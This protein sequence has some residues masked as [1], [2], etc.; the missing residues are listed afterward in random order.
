MRGSATS[1]GR[2]GLLRPL[3]PFCP[4]PAFGYQSSQP[5][6]TEPAPITLAQVVPR[7][8]EAYEDPDGALD[9]LAA[10]PD[11]L[12][13][14]SAFRDELPPSVATWLQERGVVV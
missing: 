9:E 13:A 1:T 5:M 14:R 4:S 7:A 3:A 11:R 8:V 12:T 10:D 2:A 6:S